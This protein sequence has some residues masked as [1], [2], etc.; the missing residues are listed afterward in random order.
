MK[1]YKWVPVKSDTAKSKKPGPEA[2]ESKDN[3]SNS[4][5]KENGSSKAQSPMADTP[6]GVG[7]GTPPGSGSGGT[8][9]KENG[10]AKQTNPATSLIKANSGM[11]NSNFLVND[12]L[13]KFN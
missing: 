1:V 5:H 6:A 8:D 11:E 13:V 12:A 10:N 3:S 7:S 9:D 4:S 2:P